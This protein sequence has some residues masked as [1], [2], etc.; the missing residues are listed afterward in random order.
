MKS[1]VGN[2]LAT[3]VS[4]APRRDVDVSVCDIDGTAYPVTNWSA[5]GVLIAADERLFAAG[6]KIDITLRF[7]LSDRILEIPHTGTVARKI[8]GAFALHFDPVPDITRRQFD[9]I[10]D[11]YNAQV[12]A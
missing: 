5:S 8:K 6:E 11:D 1:R 2:D 7:R 9:T 4:R 10:I 3:P 12:S